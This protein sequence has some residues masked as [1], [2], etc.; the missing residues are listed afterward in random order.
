MCV[1]MKRGK[2]KRAGGKASKKDGD[3]R[4]FVS[5][6]VCVCVCVCVSVCVC[7]CASLY[8]SVCV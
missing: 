7:V 4:V 1:G 6:R 5:L 3:S 8:L 2:G